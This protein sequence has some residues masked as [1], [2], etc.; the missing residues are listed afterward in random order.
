MIDEIGLNERWQS[1]SE[2]VVNEDVLRRTF[3]GK[4]MTTGVAFLDDALIGIMPY[5]LLLV[6]AR[7]GAGK[8]QFATNLAMKNAM[9]GKRVRY[10]ALEAHENE[11][12]RRIKYQIV[13]DLFHKIDE[14]K[15]LRLNYAEWAAGKFIHELG[16]LEQIANE[17]MQCLSTMQTFYRTNEFTPVDFARDLYSIKDESDLIILDH[18]HY[19]DFTEINENKALKDAVKIIRDTALNTQK[20]I[21]LLAQLR[22]KSKGTNEIIPDIDDFHGSSDITKI[23]TKAVTFARADID[24]RDPSL[25][26]TYM[27]ALK[28]RDDGSR[29]VYSGLVPFDFRECRYLDKYHIGKM[30]FNRDEFI[31]IDPHKRPYWARNAVDLDF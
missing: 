18:L 17:E 10:Y 22:K 7:T 25:S 16:H 9:K 24:G 15:H 8:T 20:P 1:V 14:Y 3:A 6:G 5:D 26:F 30:S 27:Q 21:V 11:I 31:R 12:E 19:F 23:A 2:R 28:F 4:E 29:T 13:S